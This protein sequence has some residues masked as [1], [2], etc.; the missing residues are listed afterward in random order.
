MAER[1][2]SAARDG[3]QVTEAEDGPAWLVRNVFDL[4]AVGEHDLL[5]DGEAEPGAFLVSREIRLKNLQALLRGHARAVVANLQNRF[6]RVA[7]P[8]RHLDIATA[9]HRL[10]RV[11]QQIEQRLAQELFVRFDDRKI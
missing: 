2:R 7:L 1:D 11:E 5:D 8:C 4:P 10:N 9:I 6:L 3:L